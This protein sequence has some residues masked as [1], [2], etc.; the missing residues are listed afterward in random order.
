[1]GNALDP[2][3]IELRRIDQAQAVQRE[4]LR[5]PDGAGDVDQVLG[6]LEDREDGAGGGLRRRG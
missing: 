4:I 3:G 6:R 2:P 5:D 1:V